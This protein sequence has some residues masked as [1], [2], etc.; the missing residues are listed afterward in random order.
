MWCVCLSLCV[1]VCLW[2]S[3]QP[4]N[5]PPSQASLEMAEPLSRDEMEGL[6][7]SAHL[8]AAALRE[9]L[10]VFGFRHSLLPPVPVVRE[11]VSLCF[12]VKVLTS[13]T[14]P[15]LDSK[16]PG[17]I[18]DMHMQAITADAVQVGGCVGLM[19]FGW[20][21]GGWVQGWPQALVGIAVATLAS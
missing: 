13:P 9:R 16:A 5:P 1:C 2:R 4:T 7:Q 12:P 3:P 19:H 17:D 21:Y 8:R 18:F 6:R 14:S 15:I 11:R 10:E 20:M